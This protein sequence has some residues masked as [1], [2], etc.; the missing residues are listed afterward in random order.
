[1]KAITHAGIDASRRDRRYQALV[2]RL[3]EHTEEATPS[4][5]TASI[6][7]VAAAS[8][9]EAAIP[10]LPERAQRVAQARIDHPDLNNIQL[11]ELLGVSR[12]TVGRAISD[13]KNHELLRNLVQPEDQ[14]PPP[15]THDTPRR[16][17]HDRPN[18]A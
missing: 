14:P 2:P 15:T 5:E 6:E 13:M 16:N 3:S 12:D 1:M 9:F 8:A 10:A 7:R 18:A 17:T 4:H 11:A